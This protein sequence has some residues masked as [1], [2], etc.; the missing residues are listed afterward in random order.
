MIITD[1]EWAILQVIE[2][3]VLFREFINEG[4][5]NWEPLEKHERAWTTS[6]A[7]YL[8]MCCGRGVHKTTTMIEMLYYWAI[9]AMFIPGDPGLLVYV[10]NKAQKDAIFPRI[11]SACTSHWLI[12]RITNQ[13]GINVS[14]GRIEFSNG[15]IFVLRIAGSSGTEANVISLHTARIWVDEAQDFPWRAWLSL[16]NVLKQ[17]IP[18]HMMWVS[19]V[20]NGGRRENVLFECDQLDDKYIS[21]NIPKSDMSWWTPEMEYE[22]RKRYHALQEDSED[23]KHYILGQHGVPTFTVFDRQR[24]SKDDTESEKLVLSQNM[25]DGARRIDPDGVERYH[26][27]E[28]VPCPPLPLLRLGLKPKVGIGYDPGYSPDP[29]CFFIM[30]QGED[31]KYRNL[32]RYL[33]QKVEYP[34]QSETLAWLD[35]VYGFDFL[36]IDMG[37][38]GKVQ[39]QNLSGEINPY[40]QFKFKERIFPVEFAG[41][42]LVAVDD[43]GNEKKDNVKRVAVETLSKWV[44][45][46]R[47]CFSKDDDDLMAE[48]ERTK[49]T[50][51]INGEPVYKTENDH[52]FAAMM[53]AIMAYEHKFGP[54][55]IALKPEIRLKL[56]SAFWVDIK[57]AM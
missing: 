28:V 8:A 14:E 15:F 22:E 25:F 26:I 29:A 27:E 3:P 40:P 51:T 10:P 19:G 43:L 56:A 1:E 24:F 6:T 31:G 16:S 53:C 20:P 46:G 57:G 42:I 33:L 50:R 47:F 11:R 55:V 2:N 5:P 35:K 41:Q 52:Q 13:N 17:D 48:L 39:Y 45:E 32:I 44:H 30:Y 7:P 18:W 49:Y 34:L 37:G 36:G 12:R 38:V 21:F 4:D 54:P 23:Y 9:N